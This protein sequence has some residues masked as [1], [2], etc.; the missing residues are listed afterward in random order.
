L[1]FEID[2]AKNSNKQANDSHFID[3]N[4]R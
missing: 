4:R 2:V 3:Q 1:H